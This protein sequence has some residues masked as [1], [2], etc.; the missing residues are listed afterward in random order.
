MVIVVMGVSGCGKSVIG[1]GIA[2]S[3]GWQFKDADSLHSAANVEKMSHGHPLNDADRLPWLQSVADVIAHW[4]ENKEQGVIA[5]S[6]LKE[7]YRKLLIGEH[8]GQVKFA[9]LKGTYDLFEKRMELRKH[10]F[11]KADMLKSQFET[12][13]E[14]HDAIVVDASLPVATIISQLTERVKNAAVKTQ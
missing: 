13:E 3:L 11:M 6:S 9:Y 2:D 12:L 1:Q 10:H 4:I 8:E 14:P 5:C 7:E